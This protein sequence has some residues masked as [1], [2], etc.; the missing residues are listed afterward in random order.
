M[1]ALVSIVLLSVGLLSG[2]EKGT[3]I[4]LLPPPGSGS[5]SSAGEGSEPERGQGRGGETIQMVKD[6]Q[7]LKLVLQTERGT[8]S[9]GEPVPLRF[10]VTNTGEEPV[11]LAFSTGQRFDFL[12]ERDGEPVWHWAYGKQFI[13]VV[14]QL[15]LEPGQSLTYEVVWPQV[16]NAGRAVPPGSYRAT[17]LLTAATEPLKSGVLTIRI[18]E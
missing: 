7:G 9:L 14:T 4:G 10:E 8:Y 11:E 18:S 5:S 2:C 17:A 16:D 15:T 12:I 6:L 1:L 13:Q 3:P